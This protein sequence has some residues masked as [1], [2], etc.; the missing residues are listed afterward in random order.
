MSVK[1]IMLLFKTYYGYIILL[2]EGLGIDC[3]MSS[4]ANKHI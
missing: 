3:T 2:K 1:K 4:C